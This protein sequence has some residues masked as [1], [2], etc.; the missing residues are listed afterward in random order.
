MCGSNFYETDVKFKISSFLSVIEDNFSW[1]KFDFGFF[2]IFLMILYNISLFI[3][4]VED[5]I[6]NHG[7]NNQ[8]SI[9]LNLPL[10]RQ[11]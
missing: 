1:K 3:S 10:D 11:E 8:L 2:M 4:V 7:I 6:P 5:M 9:D